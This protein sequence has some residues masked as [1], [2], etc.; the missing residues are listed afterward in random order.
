MGSTLQDPSDTDAS[1]SF[2]RADISIDTPG[3]EDCATCGK[4]PE[5]ETDAG[6]RCAPD[7][8]CDDM[9]RHPLSCGCACP[10]CDGAG[11]YECAPD[12]AA[13]A[14]RD[15]DAFEAMHSVGSD[16]AS[17]LGRW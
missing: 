15:R 10:D 12:A 5:T 7:D 3:Y 8:E 6:C 11:C 16:N 17:L 1:R 2:D 4:G 14:D 9:D 13:H